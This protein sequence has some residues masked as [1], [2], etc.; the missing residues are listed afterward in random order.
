MINYIYSIYKRA[1]YNNSIDGSY[2]FSLAF[3]M[4]IW[5]FL[6]PIIGIIMYL[7]TPNFILTIGISL[8][9][10][11]TIQVVYYF[12]PGYKYLTKMDKYSIV[13]ANIIMYSLCILALL[14]NFLFYGTYIILSK[15]GVIP[16]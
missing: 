7:I 15:N 2:Y 11:A 16:R 14:L 4:T 1:C 9:I 10:S 6:N 8:V 12:Y 3:P 13:T 5:L